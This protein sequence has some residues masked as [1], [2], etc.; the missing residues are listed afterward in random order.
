MLRAHS[1]VIVCAI[2]LPICDRYKT[3]EQVATRYLEL[4]GS[5]QFLEASSY[6]LP[7]CHATP[8]GEGHLLLIDHVPF[9]ADEIEVTYVEGDDEYAMLRYS[10]VGH[11]KPEVTRASHVQAGQNASNA[12]R[13]SHPRT[14]ELHLVK[15]EDGWKI[16]CP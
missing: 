14:G 11:L 2:G 1:L 6:V 7:E 15:G 10:V 9:L 3:P 13:S 16:D 4:A 12:P 8:L 5:E